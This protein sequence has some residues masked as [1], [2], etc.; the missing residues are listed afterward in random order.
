MAGLGAIGPVQ[1]ETSS[2]RRQA[3]RLAARPRVKTV[4]CVDLGL[5]LLWLSRLHWING[6]VV[7]SATQSYVERSTYWPLWT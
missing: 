5:L 2:A 1:G 7:L 3:A 6:Q 4:F